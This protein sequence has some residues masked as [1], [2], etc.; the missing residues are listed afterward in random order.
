MGYGIRCSRSWRNRSAASMRSGVTAIHTCETK[1]SPPQE[2]INSG[3]A[4]LERAC[5]TS[6]TR[7]KTRQCFANRWRKKRVW[8]SNF[9]PKFL[10]LDGMDGNSKILRW[11]KW[12]QLHDHRLDTQSRGSAPWLPSLVRDEQDAG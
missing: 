4:M 7:S 5:R 12:L 6:T 1:R 3:W 10:L 11:K 9:H 2:S 8:V